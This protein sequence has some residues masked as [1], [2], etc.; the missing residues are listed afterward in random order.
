MEKP[1]RRVASDDLSSLLC[2]L[3]YKNLNTYGR[4]TI[5]Y[6]TTIDMGVCKL[7][8]WPSSDHFVSQ[9]NAH[10]RSS[11]VDSKW[12][13]K[14]AINWWR[15]HMTK[16]QLSMSTQTSLRMKHFHNFADFNLLIWLVSLIPV[17]QTIVTDEST[18]NPLQFSTNQLPISTAVTLLLF[19][20]YNWRIDCFYASKYSLFKSIMIYELTRSEGV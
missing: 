14:C 9:C 20:F 13:E 12:W 16:L 6:I 17:L 3:V 7:S 18:H 19:K 4:C 1:E 8:I 11:S 2:H 15:W 10:T 5:T